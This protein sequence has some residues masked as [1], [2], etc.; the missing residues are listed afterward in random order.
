[1]VG[2]TLIL[3]WADRKPVERKGVLLLVIAIVIGVALNRITAIPT[4]ISSG[5]G[6]NT[7]LDT[8][9]GVDSTVHV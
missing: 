2:W 5:R 7:Y 3:I 8:P 9:G 1:M 6:N 4:G